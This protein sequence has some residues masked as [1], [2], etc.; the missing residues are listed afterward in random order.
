VVLLGYDMTGGRW[1]NGEMRHPMPVIPESHFIGH[2]APL[3]EL[4]KDC[5]R[6]G[7]MVFNASPVSK[8]TCFE[9]RSLESFL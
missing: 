5:A 2:M 4:A 9:K 6:K 8:V 7:L 1:F 3:P